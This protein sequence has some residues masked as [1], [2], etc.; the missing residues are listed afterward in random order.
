[1]KD[2]EFFTFPRAKILTALKGK[3]NVT[4]EMLRKET[5]ISRGNI[6]H[7]LRVLKK[8]GLITISE[9]HKELKGK[10]VF[11]NITTKASPLQK[12]TLDKFEKLISFF[13]K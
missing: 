3:I 9:R 6:T 4:K 2:E 5:G 10:P 8:R 1:M 13:K 12:K 11:I 7:H